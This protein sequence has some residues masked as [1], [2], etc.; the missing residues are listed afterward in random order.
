MAEAGIGLVSAGVSVANLLLSLDER[1]KQ[2]RRERKQIGVLREQFGD[3]EGRR[4]AVEDFY[5][6]LREFTEE[7]VALEERGVSERFITESFN[8][9][10]ERREGARSSGLARGGQETRLGLERESLER[11]SDLARGE[12]ALGREGELLQIGKAE[13]TEQQDIDDLLYRIETE[14]AGK[15][16]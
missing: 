9:G 5:A 10:E 14:I 15:G 11:G 1:A 7:G 16:G 8:I 2:R 6:G 13:I 4:G 12:I 3:V